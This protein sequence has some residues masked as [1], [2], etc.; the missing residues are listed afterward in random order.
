MTAIAPMTVEH[1]RAVLPELVTLLQDAVDSG[2]SLGFLPPLS[3]H[4][5]QSYWERVMM[6]MAQGTLFL[7][8]VT[9]NAQV[10]GTVQLALATQPNALHRAEVQKLMVHT[11]YRQQGLGRALLTAADDVAR[12]IGRT[13]LVLDTRRGDVSESLYVK[14]GYVLAGIIPQYARS[15]TGTLD[16]TVIFYRL[17]A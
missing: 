11:R 6:D 15:A 2:A 5:A 12:S 4:M 1:T 14:H 3:A 8:G 9:H 13:L 7:L 16:D 10:A 17:L